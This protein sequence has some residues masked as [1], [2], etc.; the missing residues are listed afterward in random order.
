[1]GDRGLRQQQFLGGMAEVQ[2]MRNRSKNRD[3]E[4][5]QQTSLTTV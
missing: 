3:S 5:F 4:V 1:V 2:V